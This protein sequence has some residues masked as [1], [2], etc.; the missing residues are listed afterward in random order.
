[1]TRQPTIP[2]EHHASANQATAEHGDTAF[3]EQPVLTRR[4]LRER[5]RATQRSL[6]NAP[7]RTAR[8]APVLDAAPTPD[9]APTAP[10]PSRRSLRS[11]APVAMPSEGRDGQ[12]AAQ[13]AAPLARDSAP[14]GP[15]LA[16]IAAPGPSANPEATAKARVAGESE[17]FESPALAAEVP[18]PL[19]R[20]ALRQQ[21]ETASAPRSSRAASPHRPA[22]GPST[23]HAAAVHAPAAHAAGAHPSTARP[24][25]ADPSA[26]GPSASGAAASASPGHRGRSPRSVGRNTF[27]VAAMAFVAAMALATSVPANALLT[28]QDVAAQKTA[29]VAQS[30]TDADAD[31]AASAQSLTGD[32]VVA[33]P[34]E[35]DTLT[36]RS[37]EQ[38]VGI[39][40]MRTAATFTND[41]NGTIQWPFPVG[42]P[43]S[44]FYGWRSNPAGFHH[45]IDFT[46]GYGVP[47]QAIA[48]GVVRFVGLDAGD[49]LGI[50]VIV[51]HQIDGQLVSSVYAHMAPGSV[52]VHEGQQLKVTDEI[53]DVGDTGFSTGAHLHFEIRLNGTEYTDPYAW[54]LAHAN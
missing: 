47:I 9:A 5:E 27:S 34:V 23:A 35:R 24:P 26:S 1:M 21:R 14:L 48:D 10:L 3:P 18:A 16:P 2:G 46:P 39:E 8:T 32:G 43:I 50:H 28:P 37:F 22:A 36:A 52:K 33:A 20:R 51:D 29:T 6:A 4:E 30:G 15:D 17:P 49:T 44:D 41:P 11:S 42:V 45:G 12:R 7:H 40:N 38:V 25:T 19:S 54:M 31:I 13:D 53:G